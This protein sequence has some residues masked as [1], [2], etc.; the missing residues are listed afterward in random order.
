M[1]NASRFILPIE[2][3]EERLR[4][5]RMRGLATAAQEADLR[6]AQVASQIRGMFSPDQPLTPDHQDML[7]AV[8][9]DVGRETWTNTTDEVQ[10]SYLHS[11]ESSDRFREIADDFAQFEQ[12]VR[13]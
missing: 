2:I 11:L 3:A 1:S 10:G 6:V 12:V 5:A 9:R 8:V 4:S 13:R 7:Q